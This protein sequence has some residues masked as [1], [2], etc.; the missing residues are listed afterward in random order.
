MAKI[1]HLD[2]GKNPL[3]LAPMEDVS[4][5]PFRHLCKKYGADMLYTEFISSDGL[6]RD[7]DK[8]V[9]KLDIYDD[10]RPVGIQIFGGEEDAMTR[11]AEIVEAA[12]PELLDI[13][14]GCPVKNVVCRNAGSGILRNI[15]KMV[16]LTAAIVKATK[17]PVTVKTRLGWDA[18]SIKIVEVAE[19]LQDV[20]I[21][22]ISIH[23]RTKHQMYTGR[24]DWSWIAKVKEN[25][26]LRIPVF[27][28]G[29]VDSGE[30]ALEMINKY[31]AD[32]VMIGRASIGYPWIFREIKHFLATGEQLAPPKLDER[33]SAAREHLHRSIQW[34]G[35]KL[36]ILEMRRHYGHY[37]RG[38]ENIKP[39]RSRLVQTMEVSE[40][41]T[42]FDEIESHYGK[43]FT[44]FA[45]G[46]LVA[47]E[48]LDG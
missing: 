40:I 35:E 25:Q 36:G 48:G 38:L 32:G 23:C 22:A 27:G 4:D 6:I 16:K 26:R 9:K 12:K 31:G 19:R 34:K 5:P 7:A 41:L 1:A 42:V 46:A 44:S 47:Y 28:N 30:A 2:L 10:E 45:P 43:S 8:S 39:F 15:D 14:Y 11:S 17:L 21:H 20:G 13:N 24:A 37:F 33:L 3:L 18:N 29:D